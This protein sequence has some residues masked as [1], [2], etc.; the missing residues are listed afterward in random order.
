MSAFAIWI[1]RGSKSQP[2][3]LRELYTL[4]STWRRLTLWF[5]TCIRNPPEPQAGSRTDSVGFGSIILT[6]HSTTWRGVKY[7][8]FS[9]L[10][11]RLTK[12]LEDPIENVKAGVRERDPSD[13]IRADGEMLVREIG[14]EGFL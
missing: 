11:K 6:Q 7:W 14:I 1:A 12:N 5:K 13:S 8:P 3:R 9:P 4:G 2:Q 10:E